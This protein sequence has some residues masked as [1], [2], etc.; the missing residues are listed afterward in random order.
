MLL[1]L[2]VRV[3]LLLL[4]LVMLLLLLHHLG[5]QV[6]DGLF[7][8]LDGRQDAGRAAVVGIAVVGGDG[9]S[10]LGGGGP[11]GGIGGRAAGRRVAFVLGPEPF[12]LLLQNSCRLLRG[13]GY[14]TTQRIRVRVKAGVRM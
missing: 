14:N 9:R 1:L 4:L 2:L 13:S 12:A 5:E 11:H 6:G 8:L 10:P 7:L 3:L